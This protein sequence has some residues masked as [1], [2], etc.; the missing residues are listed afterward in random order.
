MV[1]IGHEGSMQY[2]VKAESG[3]VSEDMQGL[4]YW[5]M[6]FYTGYQKLGMA[7]KHKQTLLLKAMI[8]QKRRQ[9]AQ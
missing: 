4:V 5:S 2:V 1:D 8:S 3:T 9:A 6:H 7:M